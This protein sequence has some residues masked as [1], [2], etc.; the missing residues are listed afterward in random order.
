MSGY[1]ITPFKAL[2]VLLALIASHP[3]KP[4]DRC[5]DWSWQQGWGSCSAMLPAQCTP[6][7]FGWWWKGLVVCSCI[8]GSGEGMLAVG[9]SSSA[10][11]R[12]AALDYLHSVWGEENR[13]VLFIMGE[14]K[15]ICPSAIVISITVVW[16]SRSH[17]CHVPYGHALSAISADTKPCAR[18]E[19]TVACTTQSA[20]PTRWKRRCA[21]DWEQPKGDLFL[22][23]VGESYLSRTGVRNH[24]YIAITSVWLRK[25]LN[26]FNFSNKHNSQLEGR[27]P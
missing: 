3:P 7:G 8:P 4:W 27:N 23:C 13:T 12:L 20:K 15:C 26:A 14:K 2:L 5:R 16:G 10:H 22:C 6:T 9:Q 17:L 19:S 11:A 1:K 18:V 21:S 24:C 25:H